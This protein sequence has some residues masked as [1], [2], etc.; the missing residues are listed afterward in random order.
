[1]SGSSSASQAWFFVFQLIQ[2][3]FYCGVRDPDVGVD[4]QV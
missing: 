4:G 1:M 2:E 3:G